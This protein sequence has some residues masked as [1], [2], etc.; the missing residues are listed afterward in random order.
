MHCSC[1][2]DDENLFS[3]PASSN[4]SVTKQVFWNAPLVADIL[5]G[6]A[7]TGDHSGVLGY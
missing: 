7:S 1:M 4:I 2:E 3:I 5:C 6:M